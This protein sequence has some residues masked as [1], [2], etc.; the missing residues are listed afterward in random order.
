MRNAHM[1]RTKSGLYPKNRIIALALCVCC[2]LQALPIV[3]AHAGRQDVRGLAAA[4]QQLE[5]IERELATRSFS[6]EELSER[7]GRVNSVL[8]DNKQCLSDAKGELDSLNQSLEILGAAADGEPSGIALQRKSLLERKQALDIHLT[9]CRLLLPKAEELSRR[10]ASEKRELFASNLLASKGMLWDRLSEARSHL[11]AVFDAKRLLDSLAAVASSLTS[12]RP[13]LVLLVVLLGTALGVGLLYT[14]R[15]R[16]AIRSGDSLLHGLRQAFIATIVQ[17][18][19]PIVFFCT[20][21]LALWAASGAMFPLPYEVT[22]CLGAAAF[23]FAVGLIRT[24]LAPHSPGEQLTPLGKKTALFLMRRLRLL[25]FLLFAGALLVFSPFYRNLPASLQDLAQSLFLFF[26]ALTLLWIIWPLRRI[27]GLA[28]TG[29]ALGLLGIFVCLCGLTAGILGYGN[30]V[31]FLAKGFIGTSLGTLL[32]VA[33]R[34]VLRDLFDGIAYGKHG[35]QRELR[36]RIGVGEGEVIASLL[37][38]K[39]FSNLFLG[40]VLAMLFLRVWG[41]PGTYSSAVASYLVDGV[42]VGGVRIVPSRIF[43]GVVVFIILWNLSSWFEDNLDK[44]WLTKAQMGVSA[45]E[46]LVTISGYFVFT[47]AA[48]IG[49]SV[50]GVNFSNLALIAGALSVGIGF[51][52]QNIVNNFVSGLILLLERPI[53]RG[54]WIVVGDTEGYV[55]RIS[56]R[57]TMIET[58]DR[59]DVIVPNSELISTQVTNWMLEDIKGRLRIP[60][61]V[62]YGSNT[63][64]VRDVLLMVAASNPEVLV[65]GTVS[66]PLVLFMGFGESSLD[67]ELRVFIRN[68]DNRLTVKSDILFAI[69]AAFRENHIEIPFPQRDVHVRDWPRVSSMPPAVE[70]GKGPP[71]SGAC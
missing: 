38:L 50:A 20:A 15:K 3:Q 17:Y 23:L 30:F 61:G 7:Q 27:N 33:T 47:V 29:R 56:V 37:W 69:D 18:V 34:A 44:K 8:D 59:A 10:I 48:I 28:A 54:D 57:S 41:V 58:F 36:R 12:K 4:W 26:L 13:S 66:K 65:D 11:I 5:G 64:L 68:V 25:L 63:T 22:F 39:L 46:T 24:V 71:D 40:V 67:F 21:G 51:G 9:E 49:L 52:L 6:A 14:L 1:S 62:A 2:G 53:K 31:A 16:S 70:T 32:F 35:W 45:R 19:L 55:K 42:Q 60:V 43:T